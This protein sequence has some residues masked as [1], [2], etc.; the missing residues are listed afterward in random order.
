MKYEEVIA[1]LFDIHPKTY[2]KWRKE[3]RPIIEL[4]DKYFTKEELNEYLETNR[5]QE[6]EEFKDFKKLKLSDEYQEFLKFKEFQDYKD[7]TSILSIELEKEN[8]HLKDVLCSVADS[9]GYSGN[10][11]DNFVKEVE[12]KVSIANKVLSVSSSQKYKRRFRT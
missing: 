7:S 1:K 11:L 12:D 4:I 6:L 3:N 8:K 10:D 9:V 2:Y 5:I